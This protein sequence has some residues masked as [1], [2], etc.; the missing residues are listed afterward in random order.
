MARFRYMWVVSARDEPREKR[1]PRLTS[2]KS[3]RDQPSLM[4]CSLEN[5]EAV[6]RLILAQAPG[7]VRNLLMIQRDVLRSRDPDQY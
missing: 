5:R 4:S 3:C 6:D 7:G 2:V 1:E